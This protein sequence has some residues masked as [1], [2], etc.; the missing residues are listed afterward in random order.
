MNAI[1]ENETSREIRKAVSITGGWLMGWSAVLLMLV[2][3]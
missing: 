2:F 1:F 3:V